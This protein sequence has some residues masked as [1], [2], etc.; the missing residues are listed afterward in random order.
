MKVY[1]YILKKKK[2]SPPPTPPQPT[3]EHALGN[4]TIIHKPVN[5]LG[6]WITKN[7]EEM[8]KET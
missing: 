3:S 7:F 6:I 4:I 2:N 8:K 1:T 5:V